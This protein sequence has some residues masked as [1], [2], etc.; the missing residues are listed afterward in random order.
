MGKSSPWGPQTPWEA[1]A[2]GFLAEVC[3]VDEAFASASGFGSGSGSGSPINLW[4]ESDSSAELEG[5]AV[6]LGTSDQPGS[7]D[8]PI[9]LCSTSSAESNGLWLLDDFESVYGEFPNAGAAG[10]VVVP[11]DG[12]PLQ[13]CCLLLCL[14]EDGLFGRHAVA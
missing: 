10:F 8:Q 12:P 5:H 7:K 3:D 13:L 4:P 1:D 6:P 14:P 2:W 11:E 9:D